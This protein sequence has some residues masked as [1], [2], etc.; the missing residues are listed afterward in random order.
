[1]MAK[2]TLVV[3]TYL[4]MGGKPVSELARREADGR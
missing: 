2:V 3:M 4:W 1:M